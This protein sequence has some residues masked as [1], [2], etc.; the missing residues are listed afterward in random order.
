MSKIGFTPD[1]RQ[2][3]LGGNG[4]GVER[5]MIDFTAEPDG[6]RPTSMYGFLNADD[7]ISALER[8]AEFWAVNPKSEDAMKVVAFNSYGSTGN[9]HFVVGICIDPD[10]ATSTFGLPSSDSIK[11]IAIKVATLNSTQYAKFK[12][13][14]NMA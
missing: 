5:I 3:M 7:F 11:L 4:G 2:K 6:V 10:A 9:T 14:F 8:G 12:A 13:L 1:E